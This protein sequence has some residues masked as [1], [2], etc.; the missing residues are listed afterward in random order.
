MSTY[1][2]SAADVLT[3]GSSLTNAKTSVPHQVVRQTSDRHL[4][5]NIYAMKMR[6]PTQ[7]D[8]YR[9]THHTVNVESG[10]KLIRTARARIL[11]GV[12]LPSKLES[13]FSFDIAFLAASRDFTQ[14]AL[15]GKQ[16]RIVLLDG[17]DVPRFWGRID[18]EQW[19]IING[20]RYDVKHAMDMNGQAWQLLVV[21]TDGA[22]IAIGED[23]HSGLILTDT[24]IGVV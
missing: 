11:R 15:Y 13:T 3:F 8:L 9:I 20:C 14:G 10:V 1:N 5:Q 24:A 23:A 4:R 21:E 17:V 18:G 16:S 12:V 22:D 2:E 6:R 7:V 19:V